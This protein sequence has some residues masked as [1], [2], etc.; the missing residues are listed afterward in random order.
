MIIDA[1]NHADWHGHDLQRFL[2]NMDENGIDRTW[3]LTWECPPDNYPLADAAYYNV[4]AGTPISF[5]RC[6]AYKERAPERFTLGYCPDPRRPDAIASLKSAVRI[7]G[8]QVCGE[9][10]LRMMYDNPD[11]VRMFRYC[12]EAGLP[13]TVHI[14]Y[15]IPSGKDQP[16]PNWWY[17]GGIEAFARALKLCPDTIFMGHAPGFWAHISGDDQYD[18]VAYPKGPVLPGGRV[19]QLME[20]CP[21]LYCDI[22]A[23]SGCNALSRD[24]DFTRKFLITYQDRVCYARDYFDTRHR[25]LLQKLN[26]PE[27]VADKIFC[28]NALRLA[29]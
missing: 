25:E 23:G 14:D 6:L 22:S 12:G 13:V 4:A 7:H 26:L 21:N 19:V 11:A 24:L 3:L 27:D 17:G 10:K 8:V 28:R 2:Q 20:E 1:H 9:L 16:W 5:A 29:P 15:E 18:K